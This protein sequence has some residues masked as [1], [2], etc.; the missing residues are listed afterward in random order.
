MGKSKQFGMAMPPESRARLERLADLTGMSMG[1]TV[2]VALE[3]LEQ[4]FA[5]PETKP[6]TKPGAERR[7]YSVKV[8][9]RDFAVTVVPS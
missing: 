4:S 7:H 6:E 8:D 9:G 1:G 2:L 3:C 5:E